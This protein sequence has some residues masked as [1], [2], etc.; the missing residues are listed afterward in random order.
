MITDLEKF[1][2]KQLRDSLMEGEVGF[3]TDEEG[4]SESEL[5]GNTLSTMDALFAI[6]EGTE[7]RGMTDPQEI[8][9]KILRDSGIGE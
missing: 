4:S 2:L 3:K 8:A 6:R 1:R 9:R 5:I 7:W